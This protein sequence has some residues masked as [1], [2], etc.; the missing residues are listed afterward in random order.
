MGKLLSIDLSTKVIKDISNILDGEFHY[1]RGLALRLMDKFTYSI[2][3]VPG[4]FSG[5]LAPS[6]GRLLMGYKDEDEIK[7]S[8]LAGTISQKLASLNIDG[9]VITGQYS[10]ENFAH[11]NISN[12]G[13]TINEIVSE[14]DN[15][16]TK[17][18]E[19][20]RN[21]FGEDSGIIGIGKAGESMHP[22]S[23]IFST[24]PNKT[25]YYYCARRGLG[26]E[27]GEKNLKPSLLQIVSILK[28][29]YMIERV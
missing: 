26:S 2:V 20:I 27:F 11:I 18:I 21:N 22:I 19:Q 17:T 23:T 15:T 5:T 25:P 13:I 4:L 24:Y 10:G 8:N 14:K 12:K 1:G 3:L 28:L 16:A 9:I 6:T 7:F 29:R